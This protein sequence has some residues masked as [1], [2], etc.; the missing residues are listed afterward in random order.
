MAATCCNSIGAGIATVIAGNAAFAD[1]E[2][3]AGF[4]ETGSELAER[5]QNVALVRADGWNDLAVYANSAR[6]EYR[7]QITMSVFDR[8]D[9]DSNA[10][11]LTDAILNTLGGQGATLYAAITDSASNLL[12]AGLETRIGAPQFDAGDRNPASK[13]T[14]RT[15]QFGYTVTVWRKHPTT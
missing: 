8:A 2:F 10:G 11:P 1:W 3:N 13:T 15:L 12:D 6:T 9:A 4:K 14:Q 7:Y 5:N